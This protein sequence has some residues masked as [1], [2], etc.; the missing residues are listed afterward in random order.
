MEDGRQHL[1]V[2]TW[3]GWLSLFDPADNSFHRYLNDPADKNS[4]SSN[5]IQK[6]FEDREQNLWVATY[7]GG[8]NYFNLKTKQFTRI[9]Q[10]SSR[11]TR[12][13]GNNI[14]SIN[15][16]RRGNIWIGTDDGGLNCLHS[17]SRQFSHYFD[18]EEK[19]PDLRVLFVDSKD[20]LWVGQTGLYL[21]D[22]RHDSFSL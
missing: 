9:L 5:Y 10:D 17:S 2:G 8:L 1:W 3:G 18:K 21:Y 12:L 19:I 22:A 4:I 11:R 15:Q 6:I 16:D 20:R 14:V 7:Y 13:L